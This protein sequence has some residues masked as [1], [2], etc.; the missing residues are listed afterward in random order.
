MKEKDISS[1]PDKVR[2]LIQIVSE[3]EH[4]FPGRHFTLDGHL[5]GSI[6]EVLAEYYYGVTLYKSSEP[7]HDGFIGERKVQIKI[8]QRDSILIS[9]EPD[10]LIV[11]YL[12]KDGDVFE[13]YNGT[14]K[15]AWASAGKLD[16]HNN[17]HIRVNRLLE[18]NEELR[19]EDRI[20]M[21][22]EI[23]KMKGKI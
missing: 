9:S 8:T 1:I 16:K 4:D 17:R 6:G 19:D 18:L 11:L 10:Y 5:V 14:G 3:L 13:V 12:N 21:I 23:L 2:Q 7:V 15:I 20:M 22:H